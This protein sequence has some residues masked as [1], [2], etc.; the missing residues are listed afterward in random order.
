MIYFTFHFVW[1]GNLAAMSALNNLML[2]MSA[3][4]LNFHLKACTIIYAQAGQCETGF[5]CNNGTCIKAEQKCDSRID[6][7]DRED[8]I[9]CDVERGE[10]NV[11]EGK[12]KS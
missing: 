6:C 1:S 9:N 3:T 4:P 12:K 10:N 11:E 2:T 5:Q 7:L 8:E